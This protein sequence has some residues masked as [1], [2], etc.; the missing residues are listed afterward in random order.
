MYREGKIDWDGN[1]LHPEDND[2]DIAKR[3]EVAG[4]LLVYLRADGLSSIFSVVKLF[5]GIRSS[6]SETARPVEKGASVRSSLDSHLVQKRLQIHSIRLTELS[7]RDS[8]VMKVS[9]YENNAANDPVMKAFGSID[10]ELP[11]K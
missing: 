4:S 7:E 8:S 2:I 1:P 6:S 10:L 5:T 9:G 3:G 11:A